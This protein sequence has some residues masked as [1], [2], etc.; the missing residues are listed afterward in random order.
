MVQKFIFPFIWSL[1]SALLF[2]HSDVAA[3]QK[4]ATA[5]K[6]TPGHY[7]YVYD[8]TPI[9][10]IKGARSS[11]VKGIV[12]RY[13]W[14]TLEPERNQYDFSP[15]MN[16]L[17]QCKLY[18]KQLVVML[19]D[20]SF[21]HG[22]SVCPS[23]LD[24]IMMT[25]YQ[26]KIPFRW[27]GFY[28]ESFNALT[29]AIGRAF[30]GHPNFEGINLQETSLAI[31][32]DMMKHI[33]PEFAYTPQLYVAALENYVIA[34]QKAMPQSRVFWFQNFLAG[35]VAVPDSLPR[36]FVPW[37]VVMGGPDILPARKA[38]AL[39]V[40]PKYE[41]YRGQLPLCCSMQPDSYHTN[42][43][44]THN[45]RPHSHSADGGFTSMEEL[46][47][48]GRD[49]LHCNYIFWTCVYFDGPDKDGGNTFDDA[50]EVIEK[51]PTFNQ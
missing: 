44:D 3:R 34:A 40:F 21:T 48:F 29:A 47:I 50:L 4:S 11:A 6:Y 10:R 37:Q 12:R 32:D 7:I 25:T 28:L 42:R 22:K 43:Y 23:Y 14:R 2:T 16:D 46:F 18:G 35:G 13:Q 49:N 8:D 24:P 30:D 33:P 38:H 17:D 15:I 45:K 31:S 1:F 36:S 27:T 19:L 51:Y 20:K 41:M 5:Q 26:G 39:S 9:E